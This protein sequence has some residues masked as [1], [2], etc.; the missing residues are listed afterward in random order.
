MFFFKSQNVL[1]TYS[2]LLKKENGISVEF[3]C[4]L[5]NSPCWF[6]KRLINVDCI[7]H[8]LKALELNAEVKVKD[9]FYS[10]V[11]P[12]LSGR[13]NKTLGQLEKILFTRPKWEYVEHIL[14]MIQPVI[15]NTKVNEILDYLLDDI[16][17]M[18][19]A[20]HKSYLKLSNMDLQTTLVDS[21]RNHGETK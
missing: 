8:I 9:L 1:N 2:K 13:K 16:F 11:I 19:P 15:K 17:Q 21:L 3:V 20:T 18:S 5:N 4:F 12:Y 7:D 10:D 6:K 14:T